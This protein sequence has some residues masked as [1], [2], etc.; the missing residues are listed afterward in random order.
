LSPT[1]K[2]PAE[3]IANRQ[4]LSTGYA[5]PITDKRD[6]QTKALRKRAAHAAGK[7]VPITARSITDQGAAGFGGFF[8]FPVSGISEDQKRL[9]K[10]QRAVDR[11][12]GR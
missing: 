5:P 1:I 8:G 11:A 2:E 7:V 6:S 10:Q 9:E 3:Q 4:Y 12:M